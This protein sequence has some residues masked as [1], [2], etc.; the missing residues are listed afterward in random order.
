VKSSRTGYWKDKATQPPP[1]FGE[2]GTRLVAY[3]GELPYQHRGA[4]TSTLYVWT[5]RHPR[6]FVDARDLPALADAAGRDKLR[7][8]QGALPGSEPEPEDEDE[9]EEATDDSSDDGAG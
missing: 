7:S 6:L 5:A 8:P 1:T 9:V 2:M 4:A 3:T